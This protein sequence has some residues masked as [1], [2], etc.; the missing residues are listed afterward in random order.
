MTK[1]ISHPRIV[2]DRIEERVY[3]VSMAKSCLEDNT[4]LVLPTGLG[5]TVIALLVSVNIL[6]RG[7]KILILAPTK[8][9]VEQH[10]VTF[11]SLLR[12]TSV[13]VMN[14]NMI[15]AKRA[16][17][18]DSYDI[19]VS[20]P[21]AIANDLEKGRYDLN[22]IGLIIYDE[23]HRGIGNY[24]YVTISDNYR[25]GLS[26]GMTA[27][28]GSNSK[29]IEE[30][31]DNLSLKRIEVREETDPDVSPYIHEI[32][33]NNVI[34]NMPEDL[35]RIITL[36]RDL[37]NKYVNEL[38]QMRLMDP[39]WPA[40]TKHLLV[41]GNTL[42]KRLAN[43]EKSAFVFR[44][45]SIQSICVKVFHAIGL[46]ETQGVSSLRSYLQKLEAEAGKEKGG[47]GAKE[48]IASKEYKEIG[49]ILSYTKVE[50]PKISRVMSIVSKEL[51]SGKDT[52]VIVFSQYRDTCDLLVEKLSKIEGVRVG[53]LIGQSKGGLKQKEQIELLDRFK[54]G[55]FN[56]IVSTS[57]GEEGLDISSTD[58]V[59][60]YEPVPSEIRTIQRRGRTGRKND[61]EVY[62]L[63]AKGTR[64]E[65]FENSNNRKEE[66]MRSRLDRL[67]SEMEKRPNSSAELNQRNLGDF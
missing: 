61:G 12:D 51:N 2:P 46:A 24:S 18:F 52:R 67:N 57:V 39:N 33:T 49:R 65:V 63:I 19:I 34:V 25:S 22:N 10:S 43:G 35:V 9:L 53:K 23:A 62:V 38:V 16:K 44:G 60:F 47:K 42:H 30:I 11:S 14:G 32:F 37:A 20:T 5:K 6:E 36:L 58:V 4:L 64:D 26:L 31:C 27:S 21:Q 3:Q 59:I 48:I 56:V 28:P 13:G 45:L 15:P 41:I 17:M 55:T 50:H 40:S 66:Q 54:D 1:F 7:K 8:P 29:K